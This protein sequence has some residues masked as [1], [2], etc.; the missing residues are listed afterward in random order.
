MTVDDYDAF[1]GRRT[2]LPM[3]QFGAIV[4]VPLTDEGRVVGV[5][6]LASGSSERVFGPREVAALE[7]FAQLASIALANARLFDAA[8][9]DLG[10]RRTAEEQL[11]RQALYDAVTGLPNRVLLMDRVR[12]ALASGRADDGAPIAMI[13]LDLDRFKVV[14]DCLGHITGDVLLVAIADR[15]QPSVRP[16]DTVAR[17]GGDEFGILLDRRPGRH[18]AT[19][20]ADRIEQRAAAAPSGSAAATCT[21]PRPRSASP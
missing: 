21:S 18:D 16:G 6:G 12:H 19:G 15:L 8:Q 14:N 2:D 9:R 5:I 20:V 7:R 4:A 11:A 3:G 1:I 17:F 10:E 13:I